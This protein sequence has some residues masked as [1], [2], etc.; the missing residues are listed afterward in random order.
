MRII[1]AIDIIGGKCVRLTRG[2]FSTEKVYNEDPLDI[3]KQIEDNG[4][5]YLHL[6][7][8]DGAKNRRIENIRVLEAIA[9]KTRLTIDYGGGL[10]SADDIKRIY[11]AGAKQVTAGSIAIKEPP[12]FLELLNEFG[13]DKLILGADFSDRKV[14]A[15]GW[16]ENSEKDIIDFIAEYASKGVK[17]VICT[18]ISKDGMLQG[19][20][21]EIYKEILAG[22]K[23]N[24]IASGGISSIT[25]I[26]NMKE[27]GCE[28]T[29]IGKAFYEGKV[30]LKELSEL[31]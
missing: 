20:S 3:A 30:T 16:L 7:D 27:I 17:Y 22:T 11:D 14:S 13:N 8:L 31:C 15:S 19:P 5:K 21:T 28:G 1:I 2:D 9:G 25:D 18:D 12:H 29:I 10:K 4:L 24:L 6:V 26:K 23:V